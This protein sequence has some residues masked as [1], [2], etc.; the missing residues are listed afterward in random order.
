MLEQMIV[1]PGATARLEERDP[2]DTLGLP[3]KEEGKKHLEDLLDELSDLQTHLYAE[4]RRSVLLVLQG[5]D[6]SGKDGTIR[7]VFT[8]VNPQGCRVTSFKAPSTLELAHD[9]L[10]RIHAACPVRG[11]I[12][13]FNRSHYEDVVTV[14]VRELA[15]EA[16]WRARPERSA[17]SS[18]CSPTRGRP[19]SSAFSRSR[20]RSSRSASTSASTIRRSAGSTTRPTSRRGS[21]GASSR[22]PTEMRSRRLRR[23]TRPGTSF[24]ATGTGSGTWPSRRSSSRP[25]AGS[26]RS[27]PSRRSACRRPASAAEVGGTLQRARIGRHWIRARALFV[28]STSA[29]DQLEA[30][31]GWVGRRG[32]AAVGGVLCGPLDRAA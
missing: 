27:T 26:T 9:F 8:G 20:R 15:P 31:P 13:I 29:L 10:W 12:G 1:Q 7:S 5:L 21:S 32:E 25:S 14:R 2:A 4:S 30:R 19:S 16:V 22:S 23:R 17:S 3:G 6:A 11:E 18:G 28:R 24:P